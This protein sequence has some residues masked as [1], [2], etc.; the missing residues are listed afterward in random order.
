MAETKQASVPVPGPEPKPVV[1]KNSLVVHTGEAFLVCL[2]FS[3]Q[4][5]LAKRT[6]I[7]S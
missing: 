7:Q 2:M 3:V 5:F 1:G 4:G 6:F